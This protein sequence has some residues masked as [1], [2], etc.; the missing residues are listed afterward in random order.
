METPHP[1]PYPAQPC[2]GDHTVACACALQIVG[3]REEGL[4]YLSTFYH[5][6]TH[7]AQKHVFS[8]TVFLVPGRRQ[9][10][11]G[12]WHGLEASDSPQEARNQNQLK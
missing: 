3:G 12:F 6:L 9:K 4:K 5:K 2:C 11:R 1:R 7:A 8:L 10:Q